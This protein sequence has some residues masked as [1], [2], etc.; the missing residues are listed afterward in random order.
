MMDLRGAGANMRV[1]K[2]RQRQFNHLHIHNPAPNSLGLE[3]ERLNCLRSRSP[4]FPEFRKS[5]SGESGY[6]MPS[7]ET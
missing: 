4:Y 6:G 1:L 5:H 2:G 7:K 3:G